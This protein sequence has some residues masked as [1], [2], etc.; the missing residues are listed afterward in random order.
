ME[1]HL[2]MSDQKAIGRRPETTK[3]DLWACSPQT[4]KP[5]PSILRPPKA[6]SPDTLWNQSAY[7][8][9]TKP[10]PQL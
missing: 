3:G 5:V 2:N 4:L 9:Y 7:E 10:F 6:R 1:P 8:A